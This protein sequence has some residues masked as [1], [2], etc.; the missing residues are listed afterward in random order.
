MVL[1]IVGALLSVGGFLLR[2]NHLISLGLCFAI[3]T[4][5]LLATGIARRRRKTLFQS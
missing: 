5:G 3:I 4:V 2:V 1:Y